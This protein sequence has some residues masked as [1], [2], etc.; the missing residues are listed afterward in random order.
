MF[1][2]LLLTFVAL[3]CVTIICAQQSQLKRDAQKYLDAVVKGDHVTVAQMTHPDITAKAGGIELM[4][5]DLESESEAFKAQKVK[6]ISG[7]VGGDVE[8][9]NFEH[10][11]QTLQPVIINLTIDNEAYIARNNYLAV[12]DNKGD[13]WYFVDL[14]KYD[15]ASLEAFIG[16]I[17]EGIVIPLRLPYQKVDR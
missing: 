5:K 9:L 15:E 6:F 14:E 12:S 16:A 1:N 8:I 11:F 3:C 2:R 13:N 7:E 10:Q 17:H 4:I